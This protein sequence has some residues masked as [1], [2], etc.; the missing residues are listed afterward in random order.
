MIET[1]SDAA[2]TAAPKKAAGRDVT[3]RAEW[4]DTLFP[5]VPG[6][7][8]VARMSAVGARVPA[9]TGDFVG[10]GCIVDSCKHR[11]ECD[12]GLETTATAWSARTTSQRP[13]A[14]FQTSS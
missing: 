13:E 2:R 12:A 6:H 10:I 5:C 11:E 14:S 1:K 3:V 9:Q 8:I 4:L 7:E